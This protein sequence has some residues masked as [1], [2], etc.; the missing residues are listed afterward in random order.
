MLIATALTAVLIGASIPA[1]HIPLAPA[2]ALAG[3]DCDL[4][5]ASGLCRIKVV[6][7]EKPGAQNNGKPGTK[8]V[9]SGC[10]REGKPLPC[11]APEGVW[12]PATSCY[13]KQEAKPQ[14]LGS[15]GEIKPAVRS[16]DAST[17]TTS[18][19]GRPRGSKGSTR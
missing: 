19:T 18:S 8:A 7:P 6:K 11:T 13:L 5:A 4:D 2:T 14:L 16:T 12:D 15:P 10:Q 9:K 1:G 3:P 17:C